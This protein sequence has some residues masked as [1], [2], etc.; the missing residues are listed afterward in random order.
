MDLLNIAEQDAY[1][2]S[3]DYLR[4]EQYQDLSDVGPDWR[5]NICRFDLQTVTLSTSSNLNVQVYASM[6]EPEVAMFTAN[7]QSIVPNAPVNAQ[8]AGRF[9]P[10]MAFSAASAFGNI[11]SSIMSSIYKAAESALSDWTKQA[12]KSTTNTKDAGETEPSKNVAQDPL[13]DLATPSGPSVSPYS[14]DL[15]DG[16]TID[17]G[18]LATSSDDYLL[19]SIASKPVYT[20]TDSFLTTSDQVVYDLSPFPDYSHSAYLARCFKLYH[21]GSRIYLKFVTSHLISARFKIILFPAGVS[22]L[23]DRSIGDLP[24]WILP[25]KG[26][27]TFGLEVPYLQATNWSFVGTARQ[28][29]L[30][31]QLLEDLP[32]PFDKAA[33]LSVTAFQC[34]A[35]DL[36]LAGLQSCVPGFQAI[37]DSF[38]DVEKFDSSD[39]QTYQGGL[40]TVWDILGRASSRDSTLANLEPSPLFVED[41][42]MLY[43]LDNF[44]FICSL[45]NFYTGNINMTLDVTGQKLTDEIRY[46]IANTKLAGTGFDY[47]A[48]NAIAATRQEIW[49]VIQVSFPY[50]SDVPYQSVRLGGNQVIEKFTNPADVTDIYVKHGSN[51]LLSYLMPVPDFFV[52]AEFQSTTWTV[53]KQISADASYSQNIATGNYDIVASVSIVRVSGSSDDSFLVS[54]NDDP[55][56]PPRS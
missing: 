4:P 24:T 3:L 9:A 36:E 16:R 12:V 40:S 50:F 46:T 5:I 29:K 25:V 55:S 14:K 22:N 8:F 30:L 45:Y 47:K 52:T 38:G 48:S 54:F 33:S 27:A 51:F 26:D 6:L 53:C 17:N 1:E 44:D 20:R 13:G 56:P 21:G 34:A 7:F 11:S 37:T 18:Y 32:Q 31:I 10:L 23:D 49:P 19:N 43:E 41:W 28:P 39:V 35:P 42:A 15:S 2:I